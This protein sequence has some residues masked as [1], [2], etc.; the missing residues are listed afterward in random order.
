V[1]GRGG[2]GEEEEEEEEMVYML[3]LCMRWKN[4]PLSVGELHW[5][6]MCEWNSLHQVPLHWR[7][8]WSGHGKSLRESE[9]RRGFLNSSVMLEGILRRGHIGFHDTYFLGSPFCC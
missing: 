6:V 1:P 3:V 8:E 7:C 4:W 2:G 9:L 5:H